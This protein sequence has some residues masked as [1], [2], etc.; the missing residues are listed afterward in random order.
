MRRIL[1]AL[2]LTAISASCAHTIIGDP[3]KRA[4]DG[5]DLTLTKLT[6]G[7][8]SFNEGGG[9]NYHPEAG[10][11]FVWAH[12]SLHNTAR[13]PRKFSFDRC[14]LDA[15]DQQ[16]LPAMVSFAMLNGS[17]NR[18][19]ELAADETIDRRLIFSYPQHQSP[20]RF[21]CEPMTIPV[22]QF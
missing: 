8:N 13:A 1:L 11:R 6:D 12:I 21:R 17:V 19:P 18:E 3:V 16:V 22:P 2:A 10:E 4:D 9:I 7:P 15:G 5:W 14:T 20:T